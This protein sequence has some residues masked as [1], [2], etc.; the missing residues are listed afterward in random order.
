MNMIASQT[1]NGSPFGSINRGNAVGY[2]ED[3]EVN[4]WR[5]VIT[6]AFMDACWLDTRAHQPMEKSKG[7]N[8]RGQR[9]IDREE[10]RSWL[11]GTSKYFE[12]VCDAAEV[13]ADAVREAAKRLHDCY[14]VM[15]N[16]PYGVYHKA[17]A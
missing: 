3:N 5:A 1:R 4:L 10:A 16:R 15:E 12:E 11:L 13:D 2:T 7:S 14:W 17:A 8:S 9:H 6:Q